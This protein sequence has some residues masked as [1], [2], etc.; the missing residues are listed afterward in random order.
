MNINTYKDP[1]LGWTS[2]TKVKIGEAGGRDRVL[3]ITTCK[4]Y[5]KKVCTTARVWLICQATGTKE[6]TVFQDFSQ[7]V[8]DYGNMRATEKNIQEA[9]QKSVDLYAE[10]MIKAAKQQY[11]ESEDLC[12]A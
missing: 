9:Q 5:G 12:F 6:T 3:E 11:A 2:E 1:F 7:T 10:A 4:R 8:I